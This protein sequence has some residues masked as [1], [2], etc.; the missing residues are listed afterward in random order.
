MKQ[1][2]FTTAQHWFKIVTRNLIAEIQGVFL[3]NKHVP[4]VSSAFKTN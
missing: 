1:L 2:A 4:S 3:E